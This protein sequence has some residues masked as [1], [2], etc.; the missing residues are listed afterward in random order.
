MKRD[1][2]DQDIDTTVTAIA[3]RALRLLY[4]KNFVNHKE[5]RVRDRTKLNWSTEEW[6]DYVRTPIIEAITEAVIEVI[7]T[8]D[9]QS[10]LKKMF[11]DKK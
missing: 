8:P 7:D 4:T 9:I 1:I 3:S 10:L 5:F 2:D 11:A 6:V